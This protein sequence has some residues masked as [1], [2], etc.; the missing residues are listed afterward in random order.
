MDEDSGLARLQDLPTRDRRKGQTLKLWVRRKR[1]NRKLV[2]SGCGR[3]VDEIHEIY[4]REVRDLPCFEYHTTVVIE[5]NS[6]TC[7]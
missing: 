4:E 7:Q 3:R 5:L 1:G 6:G 2:R